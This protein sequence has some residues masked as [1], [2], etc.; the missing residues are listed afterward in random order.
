MFSLSERGSLTEKNGTIT[1]VQLLMVMKIFNFFENF[2]NLLMG[3]HD[4]KLG[5]H[6]EKL[7]NFGKSKKK[8]LIFTN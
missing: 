1:N 8:S 3:G 6:D 5:G 7:K 2:K 4:E